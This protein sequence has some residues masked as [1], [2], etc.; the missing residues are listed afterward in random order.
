[1][2]ESLINFQTSLDSNDIYITFSLYTVSHYLMV[3]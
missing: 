2:P 3:S 1:M